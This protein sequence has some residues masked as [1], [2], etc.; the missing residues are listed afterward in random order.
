MR[1][2]AWSPIGAPRTWPRPARW[3][4]RGPRSNLTVVVLTAAVRA[5]EAE[6]LAR[7]QRSSQSS[8]RVHMAVALAEIR[9]LDGGH[10]ELNAG[11]RI[12]VQTS[13]TG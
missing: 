8:E 10:V 4:A 5:E 6:Y 3:H 7:V 9:D 2:V 1:R 13:W 12:I 11:M